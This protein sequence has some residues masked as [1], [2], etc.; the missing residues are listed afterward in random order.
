MSEQNSAQ[1]NTS[2]ESTKAEGA[3]TS[4]K[5]EPMLNQAI[6]IGAAVLGLVLAKFMGIGII[7]LV[8]FAAVGMWFSKWYIKRGKMNTTLV[9]II[10]WAK[11]ITW[12]LPPLGLLTGFAT[13][14]FSEHFV[15][16]KKKFMILSIIAIVLALANGFFGAIMA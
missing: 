5:K 12:L 8:I 9:N 1:N 13:L 7:I 14:G 10:L 2:H 15:S 3:A 11:V 16:Q 4:K 6:K